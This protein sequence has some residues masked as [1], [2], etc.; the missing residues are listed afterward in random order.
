MINP[1]PLVTIG[2]PFYN[3][4]SFIIDTLESVYNQ[5]YTNIELILYNDAS[6]D[7]SYNLV[8]NWIR[9]KRQRFFNL[10]VID[11]EFNKGVGYACDVLLKKSSGVYFQML[12]ADDLIY[13]DKIA[14]QVKLLS[15]NSDYAMVYGNMDRINET[16]TKFGEDYFTY[17]Q[18]STFNGEH[19]PSGNIFKE[20][21]KENFIPASSV[22]VRKSVIEA[23]EG[24]DT[25]LRSEDWDLWLRIS[26]H[27]KIYGQ[28]N[29]VGAYRILST[30]AMHS[31]K[32]KIYVLESLNEAIVKHK[33]I[34][35]TINTTINRH[36]YKN[37]IEMYR[38]GYISKKWAAR[39]YTYKLGIKPLMYQLLM[40]L[41]IKVN[42]KK[43]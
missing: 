20:L 40:A 22:L 35:K 6:T 14:W 29:I 42:Q 31:S 2:V 32:N 18:F 34:S 15:H 13:H 38:L 11:A 25:T 21:V 33:G 30:S 5:S 4:G 7:H 17:Q 16:G 26:K 39:L 10:S 1:L 37:T 9:N 43:C 36:L 19:P 28:N 27:Y 3:P 41:D 12:G 24:Y 8:L 23:V